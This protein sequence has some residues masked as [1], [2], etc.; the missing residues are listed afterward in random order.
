MVVTCSY[1]MS[2]N[3]V[4][5]GTPWGRFRGSACYIRVSKNDIVGKRADW[6][7]FTGNC[8][9]GECAYSVHLGG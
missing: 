3:V 7:L 6:K 5:S 8:D 2:E 9:H 1:S 4:D